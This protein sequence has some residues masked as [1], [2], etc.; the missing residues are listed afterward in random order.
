MRRFYKYERN[1][2]NVYQIDLTLSVYILKYMYIKK[3]KF[4]KIITAYNPIK[5]NY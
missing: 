3:I 4:K 1:F 2:E 5:K